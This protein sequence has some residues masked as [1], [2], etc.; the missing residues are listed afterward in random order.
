MNVSAIIMVRNQIVDSFILSFVSISCV[1][2]QGVA[3]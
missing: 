2:F 1:P 3:P